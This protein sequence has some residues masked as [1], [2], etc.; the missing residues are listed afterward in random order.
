MGRIK[1]D[2]REYGQKLAIE[3][4]LDPSALRRRPVAAAVEMNAFAAER[5]LQLI[6]EKRVLFLNNGMRFGRH[7]GDG[8]GGCFAVVEAAVGAQLLLA[9][10]PGHAHFEKF[11]QI[12]RHNAQKAQPLQ[13]RHTRILRLCKHAAVESEQ[14]Q[15]A[16][17]QAVLIRHNNP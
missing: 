12:R 11:I 10:E 15:L 1:P 14:A 6:V 9:L 16:A 3:I 5:G 4:A 17:K 8:F 2:G 7:G 13:K